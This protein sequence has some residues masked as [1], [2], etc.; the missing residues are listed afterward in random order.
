MKNI[1]LYHFITDNFA[2]EQSVFIIRMEISRWDDKNNKLNSIVYRECLVQDFICLCRLKDR[3]N[4][5]TVW[6]VASFLSNLLVYLRWEHK[7][8][9]MKMILS[10]LSISSSVSRHPICCAW[11]TQLKIFVYRNGRNIMP[12]WAAV[13]IINFS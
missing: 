5:L 4:K 2:N 10:L 12:M 8:V 6:L 9:E 13:A 3:I 7:S 11:I 1:V